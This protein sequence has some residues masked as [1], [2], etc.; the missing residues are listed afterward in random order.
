MFH[1][2]VPL[3]RFALG[4]LFDSDKLSRANC[5]TLSD[6]PHDLKINSREGARGLPCAH[7]PSRAA[8]SIFDAPLGEKRTSGQ[9]VG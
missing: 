4:K 7:G 1:I 9:Q 5:L 6:P 3:G 2:L 8:S